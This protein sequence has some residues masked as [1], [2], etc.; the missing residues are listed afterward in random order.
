MSI[1]TFKWILTNSSYQIVIDIPCRRIQD[2]N[3]VLI[4]LLLFK[5]CEERSIPKKCSKIKSVTTS[6]TCLTTH[7]NR[8]L[9]KF[10]GGIRLTMNNKEW[11]FLIKVITMA[12]N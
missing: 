11:F 3:V 1:G 4:A 6:V 7:M 2:K 12:C 5:T 8:Y 10:I 9:T